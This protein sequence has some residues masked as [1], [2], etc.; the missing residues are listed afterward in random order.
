M[1]DAEEKQREEAKKIEMYLKAER[2]AFEQAKK[3]PKLLILGS[4]DSGKSTLLKQ[5]KIVLGKGFS[6]NEVQTAKRTILSNIVNVTEMLIS[7]ESQKIGQEAFDKISQW[8]DK[9]ERPFD[10]L[11]SEF[12][13]L[14]S[15][16][17]KN[18]DIQTK[19]LTMKGI[20]ATTSH[21]FKHIHKLSGPDQFPSNDDILLLR[22]AT[23]GISDNVFYYKN[24]SQKEC[25]LH[26]YDVSG[27][28][29]HRKQWISFFQDIDFIIFIVA[30]DSY[31]LT[32]AEDPSI[33]RMHDALILFDET[34]NNPL[35][36]KS[37]VIL[38]F[39]K[40]DLFDVK[41]Q[42]VPIQKFFPDYA[43]KVASRSEGLGFFK[44]KFLSK[45]KQKRKIQCQPTCCTDTNF[46]KAITEGIFKMVTD[47]M[48]Q[49]AGL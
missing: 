28:R 21:F 34:I 13:E 41:V 48:L 23:N 6:E 42:T 8:I 14:I 11:P 25:P 37:N 32:M 40:I 49:D 3:E 30:I 22:T 19:Y 4:S 38:F 10:S 16:I 1:N 15:V 18:P 5:V 46:M 27:L 26:F 44:R 31:D 17:W 36:E 35:L 7:N 2:L 47:R 43:G 33:N 12:T 45:D 29:R 20:P 9:L 24:Q 39:N